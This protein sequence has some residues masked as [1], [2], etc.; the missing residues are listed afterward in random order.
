MRTPERPDADH[1]VIAA[2]IAALNT[3]DLQQILD[4]FTADAE[5]ISPAGTAVG[6]AELADL[7]G[8]MLL[9]PRATM[10]V[11]SV[12]EIDSADGERLLVHTRRAMCLMDGERVIARHEIDLMLTFTIVDGRIRRCHTAIMEAGH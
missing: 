5:F 1:P 6:T 7:L 3:G 9:A 8:P 10:Q 4:T 11:L 2:H 12:R